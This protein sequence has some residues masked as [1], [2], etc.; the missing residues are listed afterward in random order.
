MDKRLYW[1]RDWSMKKNL[2][3]LDPRTNKLPKLLDKIPPD[4]TPQKHLK[5]ISHPNES[6]QRT[7]KTRNNWVMCSKIILRLLSTSLL[8]HAKIIIR[9]GVHILPKLNIL[10]HV[11]RY[12][13]CHRLRTDA[14]FWAINRVS[15]GLLY[16]PQTKLLG[17]G[18]NTDTTTPK[19]RLDHKY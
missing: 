4:H 13:K 1:L 7:T 10:R 19:L 5:I 17:K 12:T 8:S 2:F 6:P 3:L 15:R 9:D 16:N 14:T 11:P 18:T